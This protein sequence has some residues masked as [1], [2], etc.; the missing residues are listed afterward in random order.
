[1]LIT[2][3]RRNARMNNTV[4]QHRMAPMDN[5]KVLFKICNNK[6]VWTWISKPIKIIKFKT[7]FFFVFPFPSNKKWWNVDVIMRFDCYCSFDVV[8]VTV[9]VV[10]LKW[11]EIIVAMSSTVV[12]ICL[13]C[14]ADLLS[15]T[16]T[17]VICTILSVIVVVWSLTVIV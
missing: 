3:W 5:F 17:V 16:V 1:L 8:A 11:T 14:I 7:R 15:L 2:T 6:Q 10:D 12:A 9:N 13:T 4:I